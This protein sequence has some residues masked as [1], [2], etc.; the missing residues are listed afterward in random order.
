VLVSGRTFCCGSLGAYRTSST[1]LPATHVVP[2]APQFEG[3]NV[4]FVHVPL[5]VV[6]PCWHDSAHWPFEHT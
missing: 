2:H 5:H 6:R 4:V 3:S 1:Q